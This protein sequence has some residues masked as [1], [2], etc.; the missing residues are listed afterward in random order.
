MGAAAAMGLALLFIERVLFATGLHSASRIMALAAL[1]SIGLVIYAVAV[2]ISGAAD[3]RE[4]RRLLD[5]RRAR[6]AR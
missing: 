6:A 3:L 5:R 2:V 4:L 1:V